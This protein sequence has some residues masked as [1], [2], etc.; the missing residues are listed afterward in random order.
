MLNARLSKWPQICV[1]LATATIYHFQAFMAWLLCVYT[2]SYHSGF[3]L[4]L[5]M[6][7]KPAMVGVKLH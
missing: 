1:A 7:I 2:T 5:Q 3:P 6:Y 4:V